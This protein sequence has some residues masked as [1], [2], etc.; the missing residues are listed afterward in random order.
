VAFPGDG[1]SNNLH[2]ANG[3]LEPTTSIT[4][5]SWVWLT[6]WGTQFA[7]LG[8][9]AYHTGWASPWKTAGMQQGDSTHPDQW[10]GRVCIAGG[11]GELDVGA[12][13]AEE[14][15]T[16]NCWHHIGITYDGT[17][18]VCSLYLDGAEIATSSAGG[19]YALDWGDHSN[20]RFGADTSNGVPY[21]T[22]QGYQADPRIA[23]VARSAEWFAEVWESRAAHY[24]DPATPSPL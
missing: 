8:Y 9:K 5:S 18:G 14:Y 23:D 7:C 6:G 11:D 21:Q 1:N 15:L 13:A 19:A 3:V 24:P 4:V 2:T 10:G 17:T 12:G 16:L 22:M 20:W